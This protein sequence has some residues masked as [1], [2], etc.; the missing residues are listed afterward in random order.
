MDRLTQKVEALGDVWLLEKGKPS[1]L[2]TDNDDY[3]NYF[4]KLA[5]YEDLEEQ[6]LLVRFPCKIGDT[7]YRICP[8]CSDIH[9]G[10]CEG[11]AW[12]GAIFKNGCNIYGYD[13]KKGVKSQ[14]IPYKVSWE[15]IPNLIEN[16][17]ENV[18]LTY[19]EA[20][21]KLKELQKEG[22]R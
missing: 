1:E 8:K 4:K 13:S 2:I 14:I 15:Y 3:Y 10:S 19:E 12:Y 22:A 21:Q 17:G 20:D 7:V 6:G 5:E 16:I 18:F 11:C 9:D